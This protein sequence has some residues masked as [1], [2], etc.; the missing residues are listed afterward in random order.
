MVKVTR[1]QMGCRKFKKRA[2]D[3]KEGEREIAK[4]ERKIS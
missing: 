4:K 2:V 3:D 1:C